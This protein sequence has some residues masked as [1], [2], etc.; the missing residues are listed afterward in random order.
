M[1]TRI[2]RCNEHGA[3]G[4]FC[5]GDVGTYDA[6]KIRLARTEKMCAECQ[7]PIYKGVSYLAYKPGL[8]SMTPVHLSCAVGNSGYWRCRDLE[9]Y[10]A[11][12]TP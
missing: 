7:Q 4:S 11:R 1:A 9:A 5:G 6:S 12:E 2:L 3:G 8:H 10:I